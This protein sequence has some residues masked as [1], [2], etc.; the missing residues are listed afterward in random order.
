M[1]KS[2]QN[3]VSNEFNELISY[4]K[5]NNWKSIVLIGHQIYKLFEDNIIFTFDY[6]VANGNI[7]ISKKLQIH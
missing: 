6:F 7:K 2:I 4:G 5:Y 3:I 1:Y